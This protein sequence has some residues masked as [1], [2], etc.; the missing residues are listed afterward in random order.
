MKYITFLV[1]I[2]KKVARIAKKGK[3]TTKTISYRLHFIDSAR[4]MVI[5]LSKLVNNFTEG[6]HKIKC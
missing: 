6:I 5:S 1:P 4:S 3:E 2:K